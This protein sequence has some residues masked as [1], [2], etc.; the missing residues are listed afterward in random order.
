M[1][2]IKGY[3]LLGLTL[4][5]GSCSDFLD[6]D[7]D[8]ILTNDQIFSDAK[9]INSVLAGFYGDTENWGQSFATPASFTK[10]D[11]GCVTDGARD[12]MQEYSD[13]QW[14][15]YPYKGEFYQFNLSSCIRQQNSL[16]AQFVSFSLANLANIFYPP[17]F[18]Q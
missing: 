11:D 18:L 6:R 10:V 15:V 7:P 3:L 8:Q 12:N 5:L 1:K 14:R 17:R 2:Y 4:I 16:T 13:N 9:M